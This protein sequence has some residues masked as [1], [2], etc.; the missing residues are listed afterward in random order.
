MIDEEIKNAQERM[1]K[2]IANLQKEISHVR[3]G[4]ATTALLDNIKIECYG[5]TMPLNQ[6]ASISTPEVQLIM[7]QPWDKNVLQ[8][9]EKAILK[10]ELGLNPTN[11]GNVIRLAIPSLNEERRME[12]VK[13]VKKFGEEGKISVRNIRRDANDKMKQMEKDKQI[14]EDE[15]YGGQDKS[16]EITDQSI[17]KIDEMIEAKEKEIMQV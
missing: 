3:T 10:S 4:K 6:V 5:Q 17:K 8:D 16:Q 12:L 9:I 1:E 14:P 2:V 15:L 13:L 11:D 7:V